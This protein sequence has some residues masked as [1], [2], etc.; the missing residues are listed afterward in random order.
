MLKSNGNILI[1][2]EDEI[3]LSEFRAQLVPH[4]NVFT[5]TDSRSAYRI[6]REFEM[7][8]VLASE[9][10][11]D[12]TSLQF[13]ESIKSAFP[14][15]VIIVQA[16]NS[17]SRTLQ[18]AYKRDKISQYIRFDADIHDISH[19][20]SNGLRQ[21]SLLN[22]NRTLGLELQKRTEEQQRILELF[23]R[24]V[25]E[26]V[27][28]RNLS[29]FQDVM[30]GETRVV[31]VLFA[32]IRNFTR[33]AGTLSPSEVVSF[34]N[35][36]WDIVSEPVVRHRGSIN[37]FIGDGMLAVF[38]APVSYIDNQENAVLC[39]LDMVE[40]LEVINKKYS[41]IFQT[42][43]KIGIGINTGEVVV[44]NIGTN[45]HIEYTVIGDAVNVANRIEQM[46]KSRPNSILLSEATYEQV[47]H[48]IDA[49]PTGELNMDGK[50]ESILLYEVIG[51]KDS[52]I[53]PIRKFNSGY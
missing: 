51:K 10:I 30:Q 25:P 7:H 27:V 9:R 38:G 49:S 17:D 13:A 19:A 37:K 35:D 52:K 12:M 14:D 40:S 2:N 18:E 53:Q 44:G 26:Q 36:F 47:S 3:L 8:V 43:I 23:K 4:F 16:R 45:S 31:S 48:V 50:E 34:L 11:R 5:A 21:A 41:D 39:A 46:T 29:Q 15:L 6:L 28:S 24:Y 33:L 20:I 32:D 1:V 22:D 42:E